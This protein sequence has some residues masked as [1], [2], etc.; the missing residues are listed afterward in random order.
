[1]TVGA[2][3]SVFNAVYVEHNR[4]VY[5]Y[6]MRRGVAAASIDDACAEVF[7]VA[8]RRRH[9]IPR[10]AGRVR[11][12]L[13]GVARNVA[14]ED[15]RTTMRWEHQPHEPGDGTSRGADDEVVGAE[16]ERLVWSCLE[17]LSESDRELLLLVAWDG[18]SLRQAASV[19]GHSYATTKVRLHR[20]RKRFEA[21][22]RRPQPPQTIDLTARNPAEARTP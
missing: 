5:R 12:W 7:L 15:F 20:A 21:A 14:F 10:S 17:S 1:M 19:I 8:W 13:L 11:P 16:T 9:D 2:D 4:A 3:D 6:L 18:L 22:F